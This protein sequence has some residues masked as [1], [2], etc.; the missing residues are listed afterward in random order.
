[1]DK[2]WK[3]KN[4][5]KSRN[6]ISKHRSCTKLRLI[7][8][9]LRINYLINQTIIKTNTYENDWIKSKQKKIYVRLHILKKYIIILRENKVKNKWYL[10]K[11]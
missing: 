1:M 9:F 11:Y 7:T 6:L 10:I 3:I 5:Y 4:R 2:T 8:L